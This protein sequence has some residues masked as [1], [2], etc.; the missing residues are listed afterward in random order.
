MVGILAF[1]EPLQSPIQ[2]KYP[3]SDRTHIDAKKEKPMETPSSPRHQRT[4]FFWGSSSVGY[5]FCA[6]CAGWTTSR[7]DEPKGFDAVLADIVKICR[8]GVEETGRENKEKGRSQDVSKIKFE[9]S[10]C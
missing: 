4:C 6:L 3:V 2:P 1:T 10:C 5:H 9:D 7:V 8:N